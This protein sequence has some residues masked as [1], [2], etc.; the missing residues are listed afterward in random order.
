MEAH[1][2]Q[3]DKAL[4]SAS[5]P[6]R[7]ALRL[8]RESEAKVIEKLKVEEQH[9]KRV[10]T[11]MAAM[12]KI[13]GPPDPP[14][15]PSSLPIRGADAATTGAAQRSNLEVNCS[16]AQAFEIP[17]GNWTARAR[18]THSLRSHPTRS[19]PRFPDRR[20]RAAR[21]HQLDR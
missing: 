11:A 21:P 10:D 8:S 5:G 14:V 15:L 1:V 17:R 6:L 19:Q 9:Q 20:S 2:A 3:I 13:D 4:G 18:A 7:K 12:A 16:M